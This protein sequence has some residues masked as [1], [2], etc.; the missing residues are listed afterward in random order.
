MAHMR[1]ELVPARVGFGVYGV[2]SACGRG[3]SGHRAL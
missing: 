1:P 2:G 3:A